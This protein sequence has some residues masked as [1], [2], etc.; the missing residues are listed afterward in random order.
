M[1]QKDKINKDKQLKNLLKAGG[2]EE[3][4]KDF[5]TLLKQAV[6]PAK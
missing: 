1:P 4:K 5:L 6:Q 2:R 3:S